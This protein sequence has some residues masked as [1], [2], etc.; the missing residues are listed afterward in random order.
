MSR[1]G[2]EIYLVIANGSWTRSVPCAVKLESFR[3][4]HVTGSV[5]TSDQL[6]GAPLLV[7]KQDAVF[8]FPVN[9]SGRELS[10]NVPPHSVVFVT[11]TGSR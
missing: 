11:L 3:P 9:T 6:D 2:H 10:C 5:I 4:E 8:D 7:N 1:D